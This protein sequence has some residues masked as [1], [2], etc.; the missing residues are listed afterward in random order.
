MPERSFTEQILFILFTANIY[1][2]MDATAVRLI[3]WSQNMQIEYSNK[4]TKAQFNIL[5]KI[6]QLD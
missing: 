2:F 5:N 4:L 1:D 6:D 3:F